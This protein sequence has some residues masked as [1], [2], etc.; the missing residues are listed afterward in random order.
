MSEN[1]TVTKNENQGVAHDQSALPLDLKIENAQIVLKRLQE[2][3]LRTLPFATDAEAQLVYDAALSYEVRKVPGLNTKFRLSGAQK[4]K[5]KEAHETHSR[6]ATLK[7]GEI[8]KQI[9]NCSQI[10]RYKFK[11]SR[12]GKITGTVAFVL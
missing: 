11:G 1:Q 9:A 10:T 4:A 3:F 7:K 12:E 6:E 8:G 2:D 5:L